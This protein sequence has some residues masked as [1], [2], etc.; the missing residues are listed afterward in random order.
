M[1]YITKE[2]N[3]FKARPVGTKSFSRPTVKQTARTPQFK[4]SGGGQVPV[5]AAPHLDYKVEGGHIV[6]TKA[7][8]TPDFSAK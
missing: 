5:G 7:P 6:S 4:V 2:Y 1:S 8:E 3:M